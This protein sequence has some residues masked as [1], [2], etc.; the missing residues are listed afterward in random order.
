[1]GDGDEQFIKGSVIS[2]QAYGKIF[3]P[4]SKQRNTKENIN[5]VFFIASKLVKTK[6]LLAIHDVVVKLAHAYI[7]GGSVG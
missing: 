4:S 2:K 1:M 7:A 5:E 3:K 6:M